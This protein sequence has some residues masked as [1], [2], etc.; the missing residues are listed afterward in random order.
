MTAH[1]ST[2]A[3]GACATVTPTIGAGYLLDGGALLITGTV[4]AGACP[5][6]GVILFGA[7][8]TSAIA[9][10]FAAWSVTVPQSVAQ[11][12][13]VPSASGG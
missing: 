12:C 10:N 5:V 8:D 7:Y 6:S 13:Q 2:T 9:A 1:A 4:N 3:V 11:P